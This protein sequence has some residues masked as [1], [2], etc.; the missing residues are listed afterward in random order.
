MT[1]RRMFPAVL[2][3]AQILPEAGLSTQSMVGSVQ[4]DPVNGTRPV[5]GGADTEKH[6][7]YEEGSY[8]PQAGG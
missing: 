5:E 1:V 3:I 7:R 4:Q 2:R 6:R 8:L